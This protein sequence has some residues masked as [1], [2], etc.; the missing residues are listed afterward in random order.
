MFCKS[1]KI[2]KPIW[3]SIFFA[4]TAKRNK[5]KINFY[6]LRPVNFCERRSAFCLSFFHFSSKRFKTLVF[7]FWIVMLL[8]NAI[9]KNRFFD[10]LVPLRR[11]QIRYLGKLPIL[12]ENFY[13]KRNRLL[14]AYLYLKNK[15]FYGLPSVLYRMQCKW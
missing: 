10:F 2:F 6:F 15:I 8:K 5:N 7:T 14:D 12:F 11:L 13:P 4:I 1:K 9:K 3:T